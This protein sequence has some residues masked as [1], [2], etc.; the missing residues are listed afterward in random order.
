MNIVK[1]WITKAGLPALV[2][3]NKMPF[4]PPA[5]SMMMELAGMFGC[6]L[7]REEWYCGY[8]QLP[9]GHP[10]DG[11]NCNDI[12]ECSVPGGMSYSDRHVP[13]NDELAEEHWY[14]GFDTADSANARVSVDQMIE[15]CET[16]AKEIQNEAR[17][18][19]TT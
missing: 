19:N 16:L 11:M 13:Q 6:P 5:D 2:V 9:L 1:N 4:L 7:D 17:K 8:V 10:W 18:S 15:Y 14:I 3:R 12:P